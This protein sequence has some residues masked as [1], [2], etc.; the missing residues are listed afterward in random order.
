MGGWRQKTIWKE[1]PTAWVCVRIQSTCNIIEDG[2]PPGIEFKSSS[3]HDKYNITQTDLSY[4]KGQLLNLPW[5]M[6]LDI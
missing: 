2:V 6:S 3:G 4:P 5:V 1:L